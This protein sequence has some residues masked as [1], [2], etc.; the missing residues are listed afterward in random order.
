LVT[1]RLVTRRLVTGASIS[2]V[3]LV[4]CGRDLV[5]A[6]FSSRTLPGLTRRIAFGGARGLAF[7]R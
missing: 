6:G 7:G 4:I 2:G 3:R 1:R 5:S